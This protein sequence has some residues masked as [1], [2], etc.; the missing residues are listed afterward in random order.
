MRNNVT[1]VIEQKIDI[2]CTFY[3][4]KA[5]KELVRIIKY[6]FKYLE[7]HKNPIP[8]CKTDI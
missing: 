4:I 6:V 3:F 8:I 1:Q 7:Q 5:L 2:I